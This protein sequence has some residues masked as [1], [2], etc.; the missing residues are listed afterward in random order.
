MPG[1][2]AK[3]PESN[4]NMPSGTTCLVYFRM[5]TFAQGVNKGGNMLDNKN[6]LFQLKSMHMQK[7]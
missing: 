4:E 3:A 6:I 1:N 2:W 5:S 7:I